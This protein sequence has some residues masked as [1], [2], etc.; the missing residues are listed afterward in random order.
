MTE[1]ISIQEELRGCRV[2]SVETRS[3]KTIVIGGIHDETYVSDI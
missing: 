1:E 2:L 3:A